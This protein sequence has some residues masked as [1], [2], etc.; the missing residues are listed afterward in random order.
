[1]RLL[2]PSAV[3]LLMVSIGMS[4]KVTQLGANWARLSWLAWFQALLATFIVPPAIALLLARLFHLNWGSTVGLFMVGAAPGAPLLTRNLAKKGFDMHLAASYQVWAAL[5]I[6]L[7]IPLVVAVGAKLYS[8]DVW[9]SPVMLLWQIV[10]KQLMPLAVGML[11]A[12]LAPRPAK[13]LQPILNVLGNVVLTVTIA[14]T[15]F[16]MGPLLKQVTPLVPVAAL[17]LAVVCIVAVR[18]FEISDPLVRQTFAVCNA[19]RHVGL[20]LLLVG[21]YPVGSRAL[22]EIACYA[23]L[24]PLVMFAYVKVYGAKQEVAVVSV[25]Q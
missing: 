11:I 21:Q 23:V 8:R 19:N 13:R 15:L 6:P 7:M 1:M 20:A 22:P 14:L 5:M 12:W 4:L 10:S 24:A 25:G 9:I 2:L 16:K 17:L 3:F 18:L